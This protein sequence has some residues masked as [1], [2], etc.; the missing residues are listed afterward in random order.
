[1]FYIKLLNNFFHQELHNPI[2]INLK[3]YLYYFIII[4]II[5]IIILLTIFKSYQVN[6][7]IIILP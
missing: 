6:F 3:F 7:A 5:I 2:I 1:M 4:I